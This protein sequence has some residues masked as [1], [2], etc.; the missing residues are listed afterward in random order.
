MVFLLVVAISPSHK[1]PVTILFRKVQKY[2]TS[3]LIKEIQAILLHRVSALLFRDMALQTDI[4]LYI[5]LLQIHILISFIVPILKIKISL[6]YAIVQLIVQIL[7]LFTLALMVAKSFMPPMISTSNIRLFPL[8][9]VLNPT[10]STTLI[11]TS[12]TVTSM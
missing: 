3:S 2:T 9:L 12:G 1:N 6:A 5:F 8:A 11:T 10:P 7:F 4:R